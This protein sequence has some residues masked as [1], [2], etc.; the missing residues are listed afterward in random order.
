MDE[1]GKLVEKHSELFKILPWTEFVHKVRG[2]SCIA[3]LVSTLPHPAANLLE[4]LRSAGA[5]VLCV[6]P[7]NAET[8]P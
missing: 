7:E 8:D 1:L 2:R 3:P 4:E 5:P 6:T